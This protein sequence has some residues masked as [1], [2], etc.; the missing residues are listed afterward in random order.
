MKGPDL[1]NSLFGVILRF[2]ENEVAVSGDISKMYHRVLIPEEDQHVHR[3]LWRDLEN[4]RPPDTYVKTV[5][6]FG[7]KPA[8]AMAQIALRKT[9]KEGETEH[10]RASSAIKDNSY[11]DDI[12]DSVH[13]IKDAQKLTKEIDSV[14]GKGGFK[15]K[16]WLSNEQLDP[17]SEKQQQ[18]TK[19][20]QRDAE[21]KVLGVVWNSTKDLLTF[22]TKIDSIEPNTKRKILSKVAKVYEPIGFA[23]A[24]LIRAKIGLQELWQLGVDWDDELPADVQAKWTKFFEEMKQLNEVSFPRG[25]FALSSTGA[26]I[27]CIFADASEHAF[28]TCAYLRWRKEDGTFE[29]RFIAAKSRVAPLKKLTI[30]R[31]ELQAALIASRLSKTIQ[32]ESRLKFEDIIYFT[33]STIVLSWI[34]SPS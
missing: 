15:V 7:D 26:P 4:S 1:L 6:T 22:I 23:T 29:V 9:A 20:I 34:Q 12:C 2:R 31:L 8:P 10:Q 11:M 30:P 24:F 3:F 5:L 17:Q 28:G 33:D 16:G 19:A 18:D 14:L 32:E 25:L 13:T 21:D 27:L